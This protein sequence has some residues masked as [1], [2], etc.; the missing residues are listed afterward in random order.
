MEFKRPQVTLRLQIMIVCGIIAK[1]GRF[2]M[3]CLESYL[4]I[5]KQFPLFDRRLKKERS[6][7]LQKW[8]VDIGDYAILQNNVCAFINENYCIINSIFINRAICPLIDECFKAGD[9]SFVVRLVQNI[10]IGESTKTFL[11]NI[12]RAYCEYVQYQ[13]TPKM[14]TDAILRHCDSQLLSEVKFDLMKEDLY[15]SVHELPYGIIETADLSIK[16]Y[17]DY[18]EEFDSLAKILNQ[19]ICI[20]NIEKI[21]DAYCEFLNNKTKYSSFEECLNKYNVDYEHLF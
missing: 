8:R 7:A 11:S 18:L 17:K 13:K 10:E 9:Y 12:I 20:D 2:S 1:R 19:E 5:F 14:V 3:N 16:N 6:I 4:G 15:F 21:Y